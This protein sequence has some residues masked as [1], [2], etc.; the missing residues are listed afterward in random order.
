V[1]KRLGSA[2]VR[3]RI[4]R[5]LREAFRLNEHR[6][7][8]GWDFVLIARQPL[9][10]LVEREGLSGVEGRVLEVFRKSSLLLPERGEG[11]SRE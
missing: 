5:V 2:V 1:S 4:K 8:S 10:E 9:V 6:V 11:A 7:Q 3:N